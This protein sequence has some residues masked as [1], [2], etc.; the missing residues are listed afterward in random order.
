MSSTFWAQI[1]PETFSQSSAQTR[2]DL[3]LWPTLQVCSCGES[4][5]GTSDKTSASG[6]GGIDT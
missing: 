6:A 3:Q 2:P 4:L 5:D 1:W